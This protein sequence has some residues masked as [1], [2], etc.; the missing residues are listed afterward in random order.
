L[1]QRTLKGLVLLL[2]LGVPV[3]WYLFLQLFGEN[4]F[5]LPLVEGVEVACPPAGLSVVLVAD[6][7]STDQHN[8]WSRLQAYFLEKK[9]PVETYDTLC[10][11]AYDK[12]AVLLY[13]PDVKLRGMYALTIAESDR[14]MVESDLLLTLLQKA[15]ESGEEY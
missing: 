7:L 12:P 3:F 10:L 1:S 13:D 14:A 5:Q 11:F 4:Q 6:S 2:L 15:K 9:I 8:Q